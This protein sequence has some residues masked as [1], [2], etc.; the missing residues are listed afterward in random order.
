MVT[1]PIAKATLYAAGFKFP[2]H[3]EFLGALAERG[4]GAKSQPVMMIWSP[5][6]AVV[7]ITIHI[8]LKDAPR[9]LTRELIVSTARIVAAD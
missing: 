6:L 8:A 7:P 9:L 4:W 3:T 5:A 2:G 1:N